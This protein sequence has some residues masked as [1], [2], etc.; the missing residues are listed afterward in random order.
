MRTTQ[1]P[2]SLVYSLEDGDDYLAR[3]NEKEEIQST[4]QKQ[5]VD[6]LDDFPD[7]IENEKV[8][9]AHDYPIVMKQGQSKSKVDANGNPK[10]YWYHRDNAAGKICFGE[11]YTS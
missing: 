6:T 10:T 11:G 9:S 7:K 1:K 3:K 4:S 2:T 5:V 8:C